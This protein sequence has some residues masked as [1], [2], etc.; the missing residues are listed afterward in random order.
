MASQEYISLETRKP[1]MKLLA[2]GGHFAAA[3]IE[4]D[5][6]SADSCFPKAI[7]NIQSS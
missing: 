2:F 1:L 6:V 4:A 7:E 5:V 3:I